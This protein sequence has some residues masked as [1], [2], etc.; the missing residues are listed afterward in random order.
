MLVLLLAVSAGC[1]GNVLVSNHDVVVL[2]LTPDGSLEWTKV[3]DNGFDDMA[4]DLAELPGGGYALAG[5]TADGRPARARPVLIR[6]APDG[7]VVS[8]RFA[9]D[10]FGAARAVALAD[11]GGTAMLTANG[12]VVRFGPDGRVLWARPTGIPE[13][14]T[15]LRTAD[16]GFLV[17]GQSEDL[18]VNNTA[19]PGTIVQLSVVTTETGA[20]GSVL[21]Q[22]TAPVATTRTL[23][24][25]RPGGMLAR[26][27]MVVRLAPDGAIVWEKQYD[28]GGLT[29]VQSCAEAPD[30]IG[31][32]VVGYRYSSDGRTSI[33]SSLLALRLGPDGTPSPVTRIDSGTAGDSIW[34]RADVAGYRVLY[35]NMS[36]TES[37]FSSGN[38]VD[39]SLD[40][41]GHVLERRSIDAS[42]A[43]T[44]TADGGYFSVGVP[45]GG[46]GSGYDTGIYDQT[47]GRTLTLH[48]RTFDGGGALVLD[49]ALPA[50]P[51]DRVLKVVQTA[52]GGFAV[53]AFKNNG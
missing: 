40:R 2:K 23:P 24:R 8:Q 33:N 42:I 25:T 27:G 52:D 17:G 37:G 35:R 39:A 3:V 46:N 34:T 51:L 9:T 5:Y 43:V 30:R 19:G 53:L 32:L 13:V 10:G 15:L 44:W 50:V 29:G 48:A 6:L 11:D 28:D 7:A 26:K 14:H 4:E 21:A 1:V 16:G 45:I 38:V 31:F 12:T 36:R 20:G 41:D 47:G 22:A 18:P 49:R